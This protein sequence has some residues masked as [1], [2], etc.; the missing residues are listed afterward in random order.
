[1][2][3]D[4]G[5]VIACSSESYL[6]A[7]GCCASV[8]HFL[9]DVPLCL[10]VDGDF[11]T[12][13]LRRTYG[14]HVLDRRTVEDARLAARSFGWG[15]TKMV[16]FW[17]CPW[18]RFLCLDPDTTVWGD[19]LR[20]ADFDRC[21]VVL[22]QQYVRTA[23]GQAI[24]PLLYQ[25]LGKASPDAALRAAV[26]DR[27]LFDVTAIASHFPDFDWRRHLNG[28]AWTG[29]FFARRDVFELDEYIDLLDFAE[30]HDDV[31]VGGEMGFLNF[32]IFRAV[33]RGTLRVANV[34]LQVLVCEENP[35]ALRRRFV[36]DGAGPVVAP[37]DATVIHWTGPGKPTLSSGD[38]PEPMTFM[39]RKYQRDAL[40]VGGAGADL[41][42]R[43]E[44]LRRRLQLARRAS[45]RRAG[46]AADG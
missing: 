42:L 11:S 9:G 28:Y 20:L 27:C 7:Q 44:E 13:R 6:F 33:E 30:A 26:V 35:G 36:V 29:V 37:G 38:C 5:I 21:D 43:Y 25:F 12:R 10:A 32:M 4:F 19:V 3:E 1:M 24:N 22:D 17:E 45:R 23:S 40:G 15:L 2:T 34:P 16:A 14:V 18:P 8:R 46:A 31:F 41:M 39:R